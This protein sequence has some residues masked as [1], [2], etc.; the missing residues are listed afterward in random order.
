MDT[1]VNN[2]E[3]K[4]VTEEPTLNR[5]ERAMKMM[6]EDMKVTNDNFMIIKYKEN[7][8]WYESKIWF[9]TRQNWKI[10]SLSY[11]MANNHNQDIYLKDILKYASKYDKEFINSLKDKENTCIDKENICIDEDSIFRVYIVK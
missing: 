6:R 11:N 8:I 5:Y 7:E 2:K 3:K 9:S 10:A 4:V 1:N